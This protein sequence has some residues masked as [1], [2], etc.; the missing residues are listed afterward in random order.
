LGVLYRTR[1]IIIYPKFINKYITI[2]WIY[3]N[4][5]NKTSGFG[6]YSA[7]KLNFNFPNPPVLKYNPTI[8]IKEILSSYNKDKEVYKKCFINNYITTNYKLSSNLKL[9][10]AQIKELK[11][12]PINIKIIINK[13]KSNAETIN[14]KPNAKVISKNIIKE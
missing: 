6:Y 9:S 10:K 5:T 13:K 7:I 8:N 3:N 4:N 12:L 14:K 11:K 1:A 2:L